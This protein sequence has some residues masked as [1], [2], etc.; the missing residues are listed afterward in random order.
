MRI[1]T[2][3]AH[4][5]HVLIAFVIRSRVRCLSALAN[6]HTF[7]WFYPLIRGEKH[8]FAFL[9]KLVVTS[10]WIVSSAGKKCRTSCSSSCCCVCLRKTVIAKANQSV[11]ANDETSIRPSVGPSRWGFQVTLRGAL[12]SSAATCGVWQPVPV[13]FSVCS[14]LCLLPSPALF[15]GCESEWAKGAGRTS[16]PEP[17]G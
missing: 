13:G 1:A 15:C 5:I 2:Y 6:K 7:P 3:Y 8:Y 4:F 10:M 9:L 14:L 16:L 12:Q 17:S 11:Q